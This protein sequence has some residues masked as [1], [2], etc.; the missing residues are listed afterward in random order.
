MSH[1][2]G[3]RGSRRA[4]IEFGHFLGIG[5]TGCTVERGEFGQQLRHG[6][7]E[8]VSSRPERVGGLLVDLDAD[9]RSHATGIAGPDMGGRDAG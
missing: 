5:F 7:S 2:R 4:T 8:L 1:V 6:D 9:V 3:V